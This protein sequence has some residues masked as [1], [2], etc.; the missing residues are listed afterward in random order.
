METIIHKHIETAFYFVCLSSVFQ[1]FCLRIICM[2][3]YVCLCIWLCVDMVTV[4]AFFHHLP[5]FIFAN[6]ISNTLFHPDADGYVTTSLIPYSRCNLGIVS[7]TQWYGVRQRQKKNKNVFIYARFNS[8]R[9]QHTTLF[10]YPNHN[11]LALRSKTSIYIYA[12]IYKMIPRVQFFV[13]QNFCYF[14]VFLFRTACRLSRTYCVD[15][16]DSQYSITPKN[17][18]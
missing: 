12:I 7:R 1:L 17:R 4:C 11:F 8:R 15:Y 18:W 13:R 2:C 9:E 3:V 5:L 6:R 14:V 16:P 10:L